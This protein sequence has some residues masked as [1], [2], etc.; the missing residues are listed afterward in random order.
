MLSL[1]L[2]TNPDWVPTVARII[3]GIVFFA[4]GTQKLFGWFGG[5]GLKQTMQ[6][7]TEHMHL[8]TILA[9]CTVGVEFLGG[10]G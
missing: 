8:P 2:A 3:L 5:P 6:A 1:V 7:M 4:H 9:F 10:S